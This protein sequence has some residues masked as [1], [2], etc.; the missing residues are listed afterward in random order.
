MIT[1]SFEELRVLLARRREHVARE[2]AVM[3]ALLDDDEVVG[4]AK[5]FPDFS[6][7][8]GEQLAKQWADAYAGEIISAA[9]N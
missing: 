9:A 1:Q 4:V 3:R 6:E 7:L 2:F 5:A 8:R